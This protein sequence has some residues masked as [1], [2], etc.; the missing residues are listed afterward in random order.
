M[1]RVAI[2]ALLD[3][4]TLEYAIVACHGGFN[5][6]NSKSAYDGC[7]IDLKTIARQGFYE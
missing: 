4:E 3:A 1:S 6:R 5:N 7:G 2:V